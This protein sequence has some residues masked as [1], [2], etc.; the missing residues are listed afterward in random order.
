MDTTK[1]ELESV[2]QPFANVLEA[3]FT[4]SVFFDSAFADTAN[5]YLTSPESKKLYPKLVYM[6]ATSNKPQFYFDPAP[7]G[8]VLY[9]FMCGV[10]RD[11]MFRPLDTLRNEVEW[12]WKKMEGDT[13]AII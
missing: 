12:E 10:A 7:K 1:L 5:C 11:S 13:L 9:K 8:D 6:S 3:S 4:R 2:S